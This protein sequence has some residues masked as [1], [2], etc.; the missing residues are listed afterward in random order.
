MN[1]ATVGERRKPVRSLKTGESLRM[2]HTLQRVMGWFC[3]PLNAE[4]KPMP[5]AAPAWVK[6][7]P[8]LEATYER[9]AQF[10][11]KDGA[12]WPEYK[13]LGQ[14]CGVGWRQ[15]IR[16]GHALRS[17]GLA[18]VEPV[19]RPDGSPSSNTWG[20]VD[21]QRP[22]NALAV[23]VR[24]DRP[25]PQTGQWYEVRA[26][27]K[28]LDVQTLPPF[29]IANAP[30]PRPEAWTDAAATREEAE[31]PFSA[32]PPWWA[33]N[34]CRQEGL[35]ALSLQA[36]AWSILQRLQDT[37]LVRDKTKPGKCLRG[38]ARNLRSEALQNQMLEEL[39]VTGKSLTTEQEL[40]ARRG[41]LIEK[42]IQGLLRGVSADT[43]QTWLM[44]TP[45]LAAVRRVTEMQIRE[46]D[47]AIT[48][49]IRLLNLEHERLSQLPAPNALPK[50]AVAWVSQGVQVLR[51]RK[52]KAGLSTDLIM[53]AEDLWSNRQHYGAPTLLTRSIL[54][55]IIESMRLQE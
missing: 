44:Q 24:L 7:S 41:R 51:G 31:E 43:L 38:I 20:L 40:R 36:R 26:L 2:A 6:K 46:I 17:I 9:L 48:E 4:G 45:D 22:L 55:A 21:P 11:F 39:L 13:T 10:A 3:V 16:R 54:E 42:A 1:L 25:D 5:G 37:G 19:R 30:K 15:A 8:E 27:V 14:A 28:G 32:L 18:I 29:P 23:C 53:I 49:A 50:E 34:I 35:D 47:D 52:A 12:A 33:T